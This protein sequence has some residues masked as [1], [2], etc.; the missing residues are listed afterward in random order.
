M[1]K[2]NQVVRRLIDA[3]DVILSVEEVAAMLKITVWGV[4]KRILRGKL[5]AHKRGRRLY[6]L[7]S[8]L[9]SY[10]RDF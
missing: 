9:V 4:R 5:P 1:N 3:N 7:K 2:Q 6:I 8:E 10:I